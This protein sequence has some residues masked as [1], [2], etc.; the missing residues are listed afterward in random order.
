ME[1]RDA[2]AR[3]DEWIGRFE[4]GYWPPLANLA[5]LMEEV[6]ELARDVNHRFGTKPRKPGEPEQD[7]AEELADVLFVIL[8]MANEQGIDLDRALEGVLEKYRR[9]DSERWTP[10]DGEASPG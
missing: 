10:K 7:L 6:G 3:V 4:E 1:I 8:C 5:R 9:R 2:Q